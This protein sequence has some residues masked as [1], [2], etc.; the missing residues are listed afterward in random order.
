MGWSAD[1]KSIYVNDATDVPSRVIRVPID[2]EPA[3]TL[4]DV[5]FEA[6][7]ATASPDGTKFLFSRVDTTSDVWV[8]D[9]FDS[10]RRPE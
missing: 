6:E 9:N 8:V 3:E 4:F 5:P 10:D 2:G 7:T 1:G